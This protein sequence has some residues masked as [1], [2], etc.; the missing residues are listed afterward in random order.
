MPPS[1]LLFVWVLYL[2]SLGYSFRITSRAENVRATPTLK[3]PGIFAIVP[4]TAGQIGVNPVSDLGP[5]Y[6]YVG[7]VYG[8]DTRY[9]TVIETQT[10][11]CSGL[12]YLRHSS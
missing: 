8:T 11:V 5:A 12:L 10:K 3:G 4:T 7:E 6:T 1:A 9:I 2:A